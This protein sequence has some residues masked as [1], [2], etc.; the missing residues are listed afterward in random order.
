MG[1]LGRAFAVFAKKLTVTFA[2]SLPI[3]LKPND[4]CDRLLN[5]NLPTNPFGK[6]KMI[7]KK[8]AAAIALS[9]LA[10]GAFAAVNLQSYT[11]SYNSEGDVTANFTVTGLGNNASST[12]TVSGSETATYACY[13]NGNHLW[14]NKW[15]PPSGAISGTGTFTSDKNG[16]VKNAQIS[17]NNTGYDDAVTYCSQQGG[18]WSACLVSAT[19]GTFTLT[20]PGGTQFT[21]VSN[22]TITG[23]CPKK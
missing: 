18:G 15:T 16:A 14:G 22:A 4:L 11:L 19:S 23:N 7:N 21:L 2:D 6:F 8:L 5:L 3:G 13:N 9:I 12:F 1:S 10:S 20:V 17:A